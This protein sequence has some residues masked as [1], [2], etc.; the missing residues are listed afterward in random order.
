METCDNLK[1]K[2]RRYVHIIRVI[3]KVMDKRQL[4]QRFF[5]H[6]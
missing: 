4:T 2:R 5:D 6:L 3:I 1:K